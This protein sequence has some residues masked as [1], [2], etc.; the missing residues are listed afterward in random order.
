[1]SSNTT[2]AAAPLLSSKHSGVPQRLVD[3]AEA[4]KQ[5]LYITNR[6]LPVS[7]PRKQ[8]VP[9][10]PPGIT[11]EQFDLAIKEITE[12]LG[13]ENVEI[14]DKPLVDGWYMEHP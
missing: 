1:M 8:E 5:N 6:T 3:E 9:K 2:A 14:N 10:L 4:A 11:R 13:T 7:S 12:T